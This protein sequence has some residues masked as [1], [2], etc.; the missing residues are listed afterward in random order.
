MIE[1]KNAMVISL[2]ERKSKL[3]EQQKLNN[4]AIKVKA[5][6]KRLAKKF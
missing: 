5:K 3:L 4:D 1:K 2:D 6:T